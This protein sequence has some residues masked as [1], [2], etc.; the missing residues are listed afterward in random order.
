VSAVSPAAVDV[1]VAD[2]VEDRAERRFWIWDVVVI[3]EEDAMAAA[4]VVAADVD[5]VELNRFNDVVV[6][7]VVVVWWLLF[8]W[9]CLLKY[10][11]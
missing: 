10:L 9:L 11:N 6:V 1:P 2:T 8:G 5:A 3:V 4:A 7:I